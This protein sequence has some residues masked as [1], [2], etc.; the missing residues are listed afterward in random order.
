MKIAIDWVYETDGD[1]SMRENPFFKFKYDGC[2]TY[3]GVEIFENEDET[4]AKMNAR[5]YLEQLLCETHIS[6]THYY[7]LEYLYKLYDEAIDFI[8]NKDGETVFHKEL[9]GNY[10]GT[11]VH[12][13]FME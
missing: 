8:Y 12:I 11:Y 1:F 7:I 13:I 6:Y 4:R 10:D 3:S 5:S 2:E 9:S